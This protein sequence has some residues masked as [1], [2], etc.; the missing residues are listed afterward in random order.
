MNHLDTPTVDP[1]SVRRTADRILSRPEFR[2][3]RN[4]LERAL[5][6]LVDE[7]GGL[8]GGLFGAGG[9]GAGLIVVVVIAALGL[10]VLVAAMRAF[11]RLAREQR[12]PAG[13]SGL[14]IVLGEAVDRTGLDARLRAA[15]AAGEW[16]EAVLA[17]YRLLVIDLIERGL[18]DEAPG[19]TTG[20]HRRRLAEVLPGS[21]DDVGR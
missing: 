12:V 1:E 7:I 3:D 4:F 16:R 19:R 18:L 15:E 14:T 5:D 13:R 11:G 9:G 17:R 21:S 10:L 6:W 2:D 8:L 20:E